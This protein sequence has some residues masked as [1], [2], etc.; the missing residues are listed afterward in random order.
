MAPTAPFDF[1]ENYGPDDKLATELTG[2]FLRLQA[3]SPPTELPGETDGPA[4]SPVGDER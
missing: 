2:V 4:G 3:G 1:L